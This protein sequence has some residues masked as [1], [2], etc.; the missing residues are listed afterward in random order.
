MGHCNNAGVH[1]VQ[2]KMVAPIRYKKY[3]VVTSALLLVF[4]FIGGVLLGRSL[5]GLESGRISNFIKENEL[6]TESYLIEQELIE[7]FDQN[8]CELTNVRIEDL[9]TE[10]S[11]IGRRLIEED[12]EKKL[13]SENYIF[14]KKKFHLMQVKTYILFKKFRE[15]CST[16]NNIILF[17]YS[18]NDNDSAEQGKILDRIVENY[19]AKIFAI[20]YNY[21]NEISF[22]ES[23]YKITKTPAVVINYNNL[24]EGLISYEEIEKA[25]T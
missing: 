4:V 3:L 22:L 2:K 25:I 7:E 24:R 1:K 8:N 12:A 5:E 15:A 23:Y 10:L 9:S 6:N 20:E 13:G 17:Y 21:P 11:G 14:L 18:L 16:S 19:D